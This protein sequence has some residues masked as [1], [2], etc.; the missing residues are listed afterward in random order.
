MDYNSLLSA[1]PRHWKN[2]LKSEILMDDHIQLWPTVTNSKKP[3]STVYKLLNKSDKGITRSGHKWQMLLPEFQWNVHYESFRNIRKVTNVV[4][5]KDFQYRLL[6]NKI[7]CNNVLFYW[8]LVD[9]QQ[10]DFCDWD[11]Q[12]LLHL[13]YHCP[14]SQAIWRNLMNYFRSLD[15]DMSELLL[16]PENI[17]YSLLHP[18]PGN[19]INTLVLL[20][21]FYL[22]RCKV[23]L[24]TPTFRELLDELE[25]FYR[26]ELYNANLKN[27]ISQHK[28]KWEILY[29]EATPSL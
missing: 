21:K 29:H 27:R 13:L 9:S 7:F 20:C 3:C 5:Y 19:V 23:Q 8:K 11:K 1:F 15:I 26:I 24:S 16:S 25:L 6:H 2:I 28:R 14:A 4:K 17:V 12:D 22:F 10:C 18:R